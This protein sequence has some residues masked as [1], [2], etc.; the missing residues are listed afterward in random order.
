MMKS[1]I[2]LVASF[3]VSAVSTLIFLQPLKA[4]ENSVSYQTF[5][6][7]LSPYGQWVDFS[8][9]GY[10]WIPDANSDANFAPYLNNGYW[11]FTEYGW[12][13]AS[14]YDWGWAV[15]HYGRWSFNDSFGWFWIP[16]DEWGPAWVNWREADGYFGW[17]PMAPGVD[18]NASLNQDYDSRNSHW[19]FVEY[20]NFQQPDVKRYVVNRRTQRDAIGRGSRAIRNTSVDPKSHTIYVLGPLK[21]VVQVSSGR[22]VTPLAIQ[23][24]SKS[25]QRVSDRQLLIYR[26]QVDK[27]NNMGRVAP[28]QV[29]DINNVRKLPD[30]NTEGQYMIRNFDS[31]S[32]EKVDNDALNQKKIN[33]ELEDRRTEPVSTLKIQAVEPIKLPLQN[34]PIQRNVQPIRQKNVIPNTRKASRGVKQKTPSGQKPIAKRQQTVR[35]KKQVRPSKQLVDKQLEIDRD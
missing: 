35:T 4:Q 6:D 33:Q 34:K 21:D 3:L 5:Y 10:V 15:F 31:K 11:T 8:G 2:K 7:E 23:P 22:S 13:W 30:R 9:Y 1:T 27:N 12:T 25:G 16:G 24:T 29:T 17:S 14:D 20:R 19:S 32:A 28:A 18:V 26:P